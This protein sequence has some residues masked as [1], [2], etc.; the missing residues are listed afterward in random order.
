M[1]GEKPF[2]YQVTSIGDG[3][4]LERYDLNE[5]EAQEIVDRVKA[6]KKAEIESGERGKVYIDYDELLEDI[7]GNMR[8][9]L[10][11]WGKA[12]EKRNN[13]S[14]EAEYFLI[15]SPGNYVDAIIYKATEG[16]IQTN[17]YNP[18]EPRD[19][20]KPRRPIMWPPIDRRNLSEWKIEVLP[21]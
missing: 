8:S 14:T 12:L 9:K 18:E 13:E 1:S 20:Y 2:D 11:L 17:I 16:Q 4:R 21:M 10:R 3:K 7:R 5:S 15:D 19:P 6:D